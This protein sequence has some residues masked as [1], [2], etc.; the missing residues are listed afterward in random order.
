MTFSKFRTKEDQLRFSEEQGHIW[1][2]HSP[3]C[4]KIVD[5]DFN[6]QFM[7]R[8]GIEALCIDDVTEYY[9]KPYPFHFYPSSFRDE[10]S[11]NL[12]K[13]CDSG[14]IVEQE[15]AVV[16]TGGC[17]L[18]FHSTISPVRES[19]GKISYLMIVSINTTEQNVAR[20]QLEQLNDEL[21]AKVH[22][23]TVELERLNKQLH[24]QTET[25]YLTKLPNRLAFNRRMVESIAL[26]KRSQNS[27]ALLMIDIDYFKNYNDQYGHDTG[28]LVLQKI[29]ETI[30]NSLLRKTDIAARFGGE[31]FVVL[32]PDSDNSAG[33]AMAERIRINIELLKVQ[34]GQPDMLN[35]ITISIGVASLSG[36]ALNKIDLLKQADD[37][38]YMAKNSGRNNCKIFSA[39]S[40]DNT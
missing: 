24:H 36:K 38:L 17:T 18:W 3:V 26:A 25:D 31:E 29:A 13:A 2:E 15:A 40:V 20:Q 11:K 9:G 34:Y 27:L 8:A 22:K 33:Y 23:R 32:L 10:M 16:D 39:E 1:L 12:K 21:E 4:T 28:D 5:L 30:D 37:A 6:L 7:S 19:S 35:N 14:K